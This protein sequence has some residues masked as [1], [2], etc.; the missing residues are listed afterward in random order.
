M[1]F[2]RVGL[3]PV[4]MLIDVVMPEF[5]PKRECS[6]PFVETPKPVQVGIDV[7]AIAIEFQ[8]AVEGVSVAT[9]AQG[10]V[11]VFDESLRVNGVEAKRLD[12]QTFG[13]R[14]DFPFPLWSHNGAGG[15][16]HAWVIMV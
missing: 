8:H 7:K 13:E 11:S 16:Q 2:S 10:K 15:R 12:S 6:A 9:T 14:D 5:V 1:I 4:T 3:H